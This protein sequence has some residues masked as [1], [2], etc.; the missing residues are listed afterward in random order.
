MAPRHL[1]RF[2]Q[3]LRR[4]NPSASS[5][6][7]PRRR[8]L[9]WVEQLEPRILLNHSPTHVL[10]EH[11]HAHLSIFIDGVNQEFPAEIGIDSTGVIDFVHTHDADGLLHTHPTAAGDEPTDFQTVGD[12]F[13]VWRTNAGDAGNNPDATFNQNQVLD[14]VV[15]ADHVIRFFVNG[16]ENGDFENY[17]LKDGD[18]IVISYEEIGDPD[19][20]ILDSIGNVTMVAGHT[21]H[22]PLNGFD[23]NGS[24]ITYTFASSNANVTG[25]LTSGNPSL[26]INVSGVDFEDNAFT[27][28]LVFE[29]YQ[30]LA[31]DTVAEIIDL[32]NQGFYGGKSFYRVVD[33]FVGQFGDT[34]IS[35]V[36]DRFSDEFNTAGAFTGFAQLAMANAGDDTNTSEL[37]VTDG[38]LSHN[39]AGFSDT[40][41]PP[42]SLNF[43]HTILGQLVDGFDILEKIVTTPVFNGTETPVSAPVINSATMITD[44]ENGVMRLFAPDGFTGTADVTITATNGSNLIDVQTFEV[45]VVADDQNDRPFLGPVGDQVTTEDAPVTFQLTGTDLENDTLTFIVRDADPLNFNSSPSNISVT[46]DQATGNV[47]LTPD[48]GFSG[49]VDILVGVRDGTARGGTP[50]PSL[51]AQSQFDTEVITLTVIGVNQAPEASDDSIVFEPGAAVDIQLQGDDG[52]ADE[53]QELTFEIVTGP[54]SGTITSFD[55]QTGALVYTPN[56]TTVTGDSFTFSVRDD[57]GTAGGGQDTSTTATITLMTEADTFPESTAAIAPARLRGRTLKINGSDQADVILV[58]LS[59]S[60][61]QLEVTLNDRAVQVFNVGDVKRIKIY[62]RGGNDFIS[63]APEVTIKAKIKGGDGDDVINSGGGSDRIFGGR[64]NDLIRGGAGRDKIRGGRGNDVLLGEAGND[65]I[66][67]N[68]GRDVLIGGVGSDRIRGRKDD[69]LLI[70]GSTAFDAIDEALLEI[71]AEWTSPRDFATRVANLRDGSG[72][73]DRLNGDTFLVAA[74]AEA[75]VFNDGANDDLRGN[76]GVDWFFAQLENDRIRDQRGGEI[77][78]ALL[79]T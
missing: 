31:P 76:R 13:R 74:A 14:A 37:F 5:R 43:Q 50:P 26:R 68:R 67:G 53:D 40:Q 34:G 47:T 7:R 21:F 48:A 1:A 77:V 45:E 41:L 2:S 27:G 69:D 66:K 22:L 65:R 24:P 52:D 62:G 73:S 12:F 71:L 78:D 3:L 17:V 4:T 35:R 36:T 11:Y 55:P 9:G 39:M 10:D 60:G 33:D 19:A 18:Q 29:L 20:P 58:G 63:I 46:I 44:E 15:D 75:T 49:T 23:P 54:A 6:N 25:Q 56:D 32:V 70:A 16:G 38:N 28:D 64:G 51:D 57:G 30:D 79:G 61:N 72:S 59:E 42:R 8:R